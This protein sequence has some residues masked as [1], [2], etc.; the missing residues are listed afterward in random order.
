MLYSLHIISLRTN[1]VCFAYYFLGSATATDDIWEQNIMKETK[2]LW[3]NCQNQC[4]SASV[5]ERLLILLS[6]QDL[7]FILSG[8]EQ[9]DELSLL[10]H[11]QNLLPIIIAVC[12]DKL[13]YQQIINFHGKV[14]QCIHEAYPEGIRRN[15]NVES[16]LRLAKLKAVN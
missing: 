15:T 12:E 1:A 16:V 2:S 14:I 4:I 13:T 5:D 10:N 11:L 3:T 6:K 7:L 9:E 8:N